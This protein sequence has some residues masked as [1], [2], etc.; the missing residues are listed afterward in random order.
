MTPGPTPVPE[1]VLRAMAEPIIHHRTDE[2]RK[3]FGE[4]VEGLKYVFQTKGD[5]L[6]LT[7]SGTGAMEAACVNLLSK[8]DKALVVS[9]GKFGERFTDICKAYGIDAAVL[10]VPYGY[11]VDPADVK[12]ELAGNKDIKAVFATHCETSTGVLNDIK[13]IAAIT[14]DYGAALVVDAISSLG[15][16]EIKTDEWG[17][18]IVVSG[19]QKGLMI[20][21][22]LAFLSV[23]EKAWKMMSSGD[24]PKYYFNLSKYKKSLEKADSPFTPAISLVIALNKSLAIIWKEGIENVIARHARLAAMTRKAMADMGLELFSKG[25]PSDSLTAVVVP[26]GIDGSKLVKLISEKYN[27][28]IAGGQ[29]EMKG[30]IFRIAHLGYMTEEDIRT[31]ISA[32]K[33]AL[34]DLG[35]KKGE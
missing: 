35:Y 13:A 32:I 26:E 30:K 25:T 17:I 5:V 10:D 16:N 27:I 33:S 3:I 18:D 9:G 14:K 28:T 22:G 2:Y 21:P 8:G 24:L 4:A 23:S 1:E 12:K 15:A 19:S 31:G 11:S 20:P 34:A 7:S 29:G 6:T